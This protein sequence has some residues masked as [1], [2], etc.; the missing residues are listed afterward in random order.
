MTLKSTPSNTKSVSLKYLLKVFVI[1]IKKNTL[2]LKALKTSFETK[3][4]H[5]KENYEKMYDIA[6]SVNEKLEIVQK[7][8]NDIKIYK[9]INTIL[10]N[11][12]IKV[13]RDHENS[14]DFKIIKLEDQILQTYENLRSDIKKMAESVATEKIIT[15]YPSPVN[16]GN[17]LIG[18]DFKNNQYSELY[19]RKQ[20]YNGIIHKIDKLFCGLVS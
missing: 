14:I 11:H 4:N 9:T 19:I 2:A 20:I 1:N 15:N 13:T 16:D 5:R 18:N 12:Y 8:R 6:N 17:I 7:L 10:T 3:H